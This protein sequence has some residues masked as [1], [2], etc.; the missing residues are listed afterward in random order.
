VAVTTNIRAGY[1][2]LWVN[3]QGYVVEEGTEGAALYES[4]K[5]VP[6]GALITLYGFANVAE[7]DGNRKTALVV[8]VRETSA[9]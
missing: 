1:G 5:K 8:P 4:G 3:A 2:K 7:W 9:P 6:V